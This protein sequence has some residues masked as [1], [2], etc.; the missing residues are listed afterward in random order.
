ML[1]FSQKLWKIKFK[2]VL[3]VNNSQKNARIVQSD[4]WVFY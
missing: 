3:R 1:D 2:P 4:N